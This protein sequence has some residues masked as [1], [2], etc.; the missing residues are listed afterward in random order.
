MGFLYGAQAGC[1]HL[2]LQIAGTTGAHHHTVLNELLTF[3]NEG[4][5]IISYNIDDPYGHSAK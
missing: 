4:N 2:S 1:S 3:K 5:P